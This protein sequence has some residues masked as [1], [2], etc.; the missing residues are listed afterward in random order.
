MTS[1]GFGAGF[2][3]AGFI[4]GGGTAGFAFAGF[5]QRRSVRVQSGFG[6][7]LHLG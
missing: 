7:G 5:R 2:T 3:L 1:E 6:F 4:V